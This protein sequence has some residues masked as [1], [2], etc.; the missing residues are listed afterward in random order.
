MSAIGWA[1]KLLISSAITQGAIYVIRPMMT[2]RALELDATASTIG[3]IA[4]IYALF[5]VLLALTFGR[6]VGRVGEGRFVIFGTI[7]IGVS[8]A[9]LLFADSLTILAIGAAL[10]GLAHLACMVGGQTMVALKS[11]T[12]KYEEHFGRYTFSASLGQMLGPILATLV[13]GSTGVI[14]KSTSAAFALALA[15][16]ALAM[17]PV[18]SWRNDAPTVVARKEETGTLRAASN[19]LQ[20]PGMFAAVFM[21]LAI[22]ST[23][24]ILVVFLPL[25]GNENQFSAFSIGVIISI[26]AATSMAS[27]FFLG[28]LSARYSTKQLLVTS[29]AISVVACAAMAFAPNPWVLGAIVFVAGFSLGVGQ[30]LTMSL[31]SQLTVPEERALAVSTRLTGNRLGQFVIPAGAGLLAAGSGTSAVFIGLSI[32]VASTFLPRGRG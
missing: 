23:A 12:D 1:N 19:L 6:L 22:S 28:R 30:P 18:I 27:R 9:I 10:S 5:P 32:L 25:Y 13:A 7:F 29:N 24:D 31:I 26:R 11:P 14:P 21:S 15:L 17:V 20:K 16:S 4:A 2:Y 8:A 3:F